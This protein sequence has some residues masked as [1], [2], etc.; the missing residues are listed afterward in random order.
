MKLLPSSNDLPAK[1]SQFPS[2]LCESQESQT[3]VKEVRNC[4]N[5]M[6]TW[7]W[8]EFQIRGFQ[9]QNA[10]PGA[11]WLVAAGA[12]KKKKVDF[13]K[14]LLD[15]ALLSTNFSSIYYIELKSTEICEQIVKTACIFIVSM[16]KPPK[17]FTT[18]CYM[19]WELVKEWQVAGAPKNSFGQNLHVFE[20][21]H[22][23]YT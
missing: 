8:V 18:H 5:I 3:T 14:F 13:I 11:S 17:C 22:I 4:Q 6:I 21:I 23:L 9:D 1:K 20:V 19:V 2:M 7:T 12:S 10:R 15:E 16:A